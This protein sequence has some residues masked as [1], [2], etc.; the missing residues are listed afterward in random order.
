MLHLIP[1]SQ[2][3]MKPWDEYIGPWKA[4]PVNKLIQLRAALSTFCSFSCAAY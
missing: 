4:I 2:R 1:I 3:K